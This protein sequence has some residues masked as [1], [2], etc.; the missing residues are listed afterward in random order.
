MSN[1]AILVIDDDDDIRETM[2]LLLGT[3]G[4]TAVGLRD[5][6][7]GLDWIARHE[8]PALILLDLRMPRMSGPEFVEAL[9]R[10]PRRAGIPIVILSGD[11]TCGETARALGIDQCLVK[12]VDLDRLIDTVR[13]V[14][15]AAQPA[16][17]PP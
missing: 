6:L 14:M 12:P 17:A 8:R 11:A 16:A 4:W 15:S 5:G 1:R 10:D 7:E 3:E 2:E 9:R 13:S